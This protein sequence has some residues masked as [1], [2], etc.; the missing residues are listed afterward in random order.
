MSAESKFYTFRQNNSGGS[1]DQDD[2]VS[3]Y[4]IVEAINA[5]QA[6][7]RAQDAGL[8]FDGCRE[9]IDCS[10]CGDRWHEV[11]E[12]DACAVPSIYGRP[13]AEYVND[14]PKWMDDD[15]RIHYLDGRVEKFATKSKQ[16]SA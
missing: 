12:S 8:Y 3:L 7:A 9:G 13:I 4:V 5:D 11:D 6:S 2:N 15:V 10:C 1:F 14:W 16:V